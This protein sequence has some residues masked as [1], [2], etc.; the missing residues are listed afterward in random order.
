MTLERPR[1]SVIVP[2]ADTPVRFF[3]E[4][5]ESVFAQTV[6]TWELLLVDDGCT[7]GAAAKA[8]SLADCHPDRVRLLQHAGGENRGPSASRN[9][10]LREARGEFAA[11]LDSDDVW[12]PQK[13]EQQTR[14]LQD[15]PDVG[16]LYGSSL[17]WYSWT[18]L[19]AD[20]GRDFIP[21]LG[22]PSGVVLPPPGPL[23]RHLSG[24]AAVP[25]PSSIL[26]RRRT[27]L[28]VN[29]FEEWFRGLYEDQLFFA[30]MCLEAPVMASDSCWD[31][32]RQHTASFSGQTT[33]PDERDSRRAYLDWLEEYAAERGREHPELA[34]ALRRERWK[35]RR[36]AVWRFL[37][38]GIK[39]LRR[40][41]RVWNPPPTAAGQDP[42]KPGDD[43]GSL[44]GVG[45]R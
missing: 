35:M 1:V 15:D 31:R 24:R 4:A 32:Y 41:R 3:H 44:E 7:G 21:E 30:K 16:M 14:I 26:V 12:R 36:P 40:I 27:A 5:V 45:P 29:G 18:G 42:R 2:F 38:L 37:R 25:T 9:L 19:P 20:E 23:P 8:R 34:R 6:D 13:L 10:G 17:Y 43:D 22:V 33:G 39:A 11:F 28:D